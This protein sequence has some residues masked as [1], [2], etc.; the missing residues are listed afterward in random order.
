VIGGEREKGKGGMRG[1]ERRRG[2][3]VMRGWCSEFRWSLSISCCVLFCLTVTTP[4]SKEKKTL[5]P[6]VI[7]LSKRLGIRLKGKWQLQNLS[8]NYIK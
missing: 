2:D 7:T 5:R 3:G 1:D 4:Y 8:S 6:K